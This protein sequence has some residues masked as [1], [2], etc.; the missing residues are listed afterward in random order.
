MRTGR[1]DRDPALITDAQPSLEQEQRA[2]KRVYLVLMVVHLS[3]LILAGL[4]AHYWLLALAIVALTGPLPWVAVVL[5][6][7]P[8]FGAPTRARV[9][10]PR[11][12][13]DSTEDPLR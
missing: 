9:P 4:L 5:A 3:G 11:R 1:H 12:E 6:N 7:S 8:R 2:R 10:L 13:I